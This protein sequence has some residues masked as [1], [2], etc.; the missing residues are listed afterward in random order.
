MWQDIGLNFQWSNK[1]GYVLTCRT[2]SVGR[3]SLAK[4]MY[5]YSVTNGS[6]VSKAVERFH[7]VRLTGCWWIVVNCSDLN[8]FSFFPLHLPDPLS[9]LSPNP[10]PLSHITRPRSSARSSAALQEHKEHMERWEVG[11]E[12]PPDAGR[13]ESSVSNQVLVWPSKPLSWWNTWEPHA[14]GILML[15]LT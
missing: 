2:K 8:M 5:I 13:R 6:S 1:S 14:M 11:G 9:S 7:K 15:L 10:K 12:P 3:L 4:L